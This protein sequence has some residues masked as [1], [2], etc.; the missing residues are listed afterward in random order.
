M[1]SEQRQ[2][3][4]AMLEMPEPQIQALALP[5]HHEVT[6]GESLRSG[7]SVELVKARL[8]DLPAAICSGA[9]ISH[10]SEELVC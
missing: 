7:D 5:L 6:G 2:M 1:P 3:M 10:L 4:T 9:L 8:Q